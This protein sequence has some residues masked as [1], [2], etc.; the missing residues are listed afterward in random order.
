MAVPVHWGGADGD[1]VDDDERSVNRSNEPLRRPTC[2]HA[3]EKAGCFDEN[4][5]TGERDVC[6]GGNTTQSDSG[7]E[8]T[9]LL[10]LWRSLNDADDAAETDVAPFGSGIVLVHISRL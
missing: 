6:G 9:L 10:L 2:S 5:E 3:R 4:E 1:A 7:V 8:A